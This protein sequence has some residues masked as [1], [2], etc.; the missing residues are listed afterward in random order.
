LGCQERNAGNLNDRLFYN[1]TC[2]TISEVC[3]NFGLLGAN[4][5]FCTDGTRAIPITDVVN[6]T[7]AAEEF[8]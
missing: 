8:F 3:G 6:R 5:S 4:V 1:Q 7:L 2:R